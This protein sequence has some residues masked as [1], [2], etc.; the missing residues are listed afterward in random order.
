LGYP[1]VLFVQ[2]NNAEVVDDFTRAFLTMIDDTDALSSV[3]G[4]VSLRAMINSGIDRFPPTSQVNGTCYAH[5]VAAVFHLAMRRI[6]GRDG[7]YPAFDAIK[8]ELIDLYGDKGAVS[9]HVL[10]EQSPQYRLRWRETKGELEAR[11]C[12]HVRRPVIALL[13]DARRVRPI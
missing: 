10:K 6:I 9:K 4:D 3:V 11:R 2:A 12:I 7:G 1:A 8:D 13:S 5:A